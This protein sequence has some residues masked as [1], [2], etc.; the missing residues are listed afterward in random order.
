MVERG[1]GQRG[2]GEKISEES[3]KGGKG[4]RDSM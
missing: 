2:G 1:R 3:H 4:K